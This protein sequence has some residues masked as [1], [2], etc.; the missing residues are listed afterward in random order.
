[1]SEDQREVLC[2][3]IYDLLVQK[4]FDNP[5]GHLFADVFAEVWHYVSDSV[6]G[7]QN[8]QDRLKTLL[9]SATQYFVLFRKRIRVAKNCGQ[10]A[11]GGEL[12]VRLVV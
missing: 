8:A 3:Y 11:R 7:R 1:M 4:K 6:E 12:M 2:K 10:F 9:R 5:N